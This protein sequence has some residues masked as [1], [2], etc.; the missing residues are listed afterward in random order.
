[1]RMA[2]AISHRHPEAKISIFYMDMQNCGKHF[3]VFYERC[4][5]HVRFVRFMPGDIL[6]GEGDQLTL[7]Y[8]T[9]EDGRP[10]R[11]PFDLVV[12]SVGIMPGASNARLAD[13]LKL[14]LDQH[15]FFSF[16]DPMDQTTTK[17]DGIFLAGTAQ[18]PKDIADSMGQAGQAAQQVAQYLGVL[19]CLK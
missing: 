3:S 5:K 16:T 18:G 17:Q 9:E 6:Q 8:A 2:E 7:C 19:A 15:G 1:M 4:K 13:M 11:E 14:D 10:V 12:L